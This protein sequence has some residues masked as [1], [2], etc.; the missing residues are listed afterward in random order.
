MSGGRA[1]H[2]SLAPANPIGTGARGEVGRLLIC[3]SETALVQQLEEFLD[4]LRIELFAG[5][6]ANVLPSCKDAPG[7]SVGPLRPEGVPHVG[8][9]EHPG[10]AGKC[11]VDR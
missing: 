2:S 8:D 1:P 9:R 5:L 7:R 3:I 4:N 6:R 11:R 10:R